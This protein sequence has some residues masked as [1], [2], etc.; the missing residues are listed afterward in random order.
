MAV[1]S[2]NH[3]LLRY[4]FKRKGYDPFPPELCL[5]LVY[6]DALK[7]LRS[8]PSYKALQ[9]PIV[10]MLCRFEMARFKPFGLAIANR[11]RDKEPVLDLG[12]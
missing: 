5:Y 12:E 10:Q 2:T 9:R 7:P 6:F 4:A 3:S 1:L 8:A 11:Q